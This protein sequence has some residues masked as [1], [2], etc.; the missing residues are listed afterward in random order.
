MALSNQWFS[1]HSLAYIFPK[2]IDPI[3]RHLWK[4][5]SLETKKHGRC[6]LVNSL[7]LGA[8]FYIRFLCTFI[9]SEFLISTAHYTDPEINTRKYYLNG[10][11]IGY[12]NGWLSIER[13][14]QNRGQLINRKLDVESLFYTDIHLMF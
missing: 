3:H 9:Y 5:L 11:H 8:W 7:F 12:P 6:F 13:V 1:Y 14:D 2:H 10:K 4:K